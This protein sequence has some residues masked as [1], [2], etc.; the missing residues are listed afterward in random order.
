MTIRLNGAGKR[1]NREWIF[2]N[3][4][5]EFKAGQIVAITGPNGSGKSTLL[6]VLWAQTPPTEGEVDYVKDGVSVHPSDAYSDF[7][8]AAPYMEL[9]DDFNPQEQVDFHFSFKTLKAGITHNGLLESAGLS[10]ARNRPLRHFSSGMRQ[11]LK[12]ALAF[13]SD[14]PVIFLDEPTTNLDLNG[15]DWYRQQ[16]ENCRDRLVIIATNTP[17]DYP[18]SSLNIHLPD[19][20]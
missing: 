1:F 4:S 8:I 2:R 6:S 12:L 10:G 18:T 7:G 9:F 17:G 16:L 14:T 13:S 3:L 15:A 19:C 20:K 11:R 5:F